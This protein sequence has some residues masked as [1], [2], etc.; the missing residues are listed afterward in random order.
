[1]RFLLS[2]LVASFALLPVSK[3]AAQEKEPAKAK[4]IAEVKKEIAEHRA[5]LATLEAELLTLQA[6]P[7]VDLLAMLDVKKDSVA[8]DWKFKDKLLLGPGTPDAKLAFP[9]RPSGDYTFTVKFKRTE[10]LGGPILCLPVGER[11]VNFALDAYNGE[12][13]ALEAVD[14]AYVNFPGNPTQ[15]RG[16]HVVTNQS[17]TLE[18][19][20]RR[21]GDTATIRIDLDGKR[22]VDWSGNPN[23]FTL[24]PAWRLNDDRQI[25]LRSW[26]SFEYEAARLR[27]LAGQ[28]NPIR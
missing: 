6:G 21:N 11:H 22:L 2:V 16:K 23:R 13:T 12:F 5:R 20:V 1:M 17:H 4:R 18:A 10:G 26:Q 3:S 24:H 14:G 8:G 15:I 19:T 25:G 28:A 7:P 27:M 9:V